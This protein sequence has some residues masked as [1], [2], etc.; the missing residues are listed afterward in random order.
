M[1]LFCS[2]HPESTQGG[3]EPCGDEKEEDE[4]EGTTRA[5]RGDLEYLRDM[6]E[7]VALRGKINNVAHRLRT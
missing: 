5:Y 7:L 6:V 4:E 1:V 2:G 3:T